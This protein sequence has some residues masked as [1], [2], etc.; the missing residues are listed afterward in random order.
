[1]ANRP[2]LFGVQ[3]IFGSFILLSGTSYFTIND[4]CA[5]NKV[6]SLINWY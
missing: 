3:R 1:M 6:V 5:N 4:L 2:A